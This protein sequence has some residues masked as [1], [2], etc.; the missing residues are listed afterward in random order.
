MGI[1]DIEPV[2]TYV[3]DT[4]EQHEFLPGTIEPPAN[5]SL[6]H[7][8]GEMNEKMGNMSDPIASFAKP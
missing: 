8:I 7:T 6:D 2:V 5:S 1:K 4:G 3:S